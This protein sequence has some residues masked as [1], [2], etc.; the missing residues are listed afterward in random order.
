MLVTLF[1]LYNTP[2]MF[3]NYINYILYNAFNDYCT[4]YLNNV[5]IFLKIYTEYIKYVNEII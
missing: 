1:G 5:F 3:Q 4:V 2:V